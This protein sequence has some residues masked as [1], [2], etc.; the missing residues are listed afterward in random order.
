MSVGLLVL[1]RIRQLGRGAE[2]GGAADE[3]LVD[4]LPEALR[5]HE[6]LVV[7]ARD[8]DRRGERGDGAHVEVKRGPVVLALGDEPVIELHHG[9][10]RVGLLAAALAQFD[11]RVGLR[12][13]G[14]DHAARAVILE[15]APHEGD[16]IGQQCRGQRVALVT[17]VQGTIE[18]EA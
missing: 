6:G 14:S 11:Q 17:N 15:G 9:G 12:R 7:E 10:A 4:L 5:P 2:A 18:G 1:V 16:A 13:T 3:R 8:E